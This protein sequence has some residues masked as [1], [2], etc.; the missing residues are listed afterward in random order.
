MNNE[1]DRQNAINEID[2]EIQKMMAKMGAAGIRIMLHNE[3]IMVDYHQFRARRI[4]T[5]LLSDNGR[6]CKCDNCNCQNN[7]I[8]GCSDRC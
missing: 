8:G 4:N 1:K 3:L 6:S 2:G 7:S 5:A